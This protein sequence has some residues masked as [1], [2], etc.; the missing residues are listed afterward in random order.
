[1]NRAEAVAGALR[2]ERP[3]LVLEVSG[4]GDSD[5][6]VTEDP[7]DAST[8]AANRRVEIVYSG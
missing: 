5:P 6:A 1:M 3:D 8:Y 2:S 4:V 7:E